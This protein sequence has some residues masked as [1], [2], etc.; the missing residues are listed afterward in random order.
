[1][2]TEQSNLI[3]SLDQLSY[4]EAVELVN[5]VKALNK[6]QI[7]FQ[8]Y[9][10][11]LNQYYIDYY[12][13]YGH[14]PNTA[15]QPEM[16]QQQQQQQSSTVSTG[17]TREELAKALDLETGNTI[18]F[19]VNYKTTPTGKELM[20]VAEKAL[21]AIYPAADV[22]RK[23]SSDPNIICSVML[24]SMGGSPIN[25]R[26]FVKEHGIE[27]HFTDTLQAL[28]KEIQK[29]AKEAVN[30]AATLQH[31]SGDKEYEYYSRLL[32]E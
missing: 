26:V 28:G 5:Y 25:Y 7:D 16:T 13:I 21:K 17:L 23:Q 32:S 9:T 20:E 31:D 1:M 3:T 15:A 4:E 6:Y 30:S 8:E 2:S 12:A 11:K 19:S 10:N 18:V 14:Y 27:R 22:M 24:V 29:S